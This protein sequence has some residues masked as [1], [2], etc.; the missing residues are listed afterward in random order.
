MLSHMVYV[1]CLSPWVF[2]DFQVFETAMFVSQLSLPCKI[3][4]LI[5]RFVCHIQQE[6]EDVPYPILKWQP[7]SGDSMNWFKGKSAGNPCF[8]PQKYSFPVDFPSNQFWDGHVGSQKSVGTIQS[9]C[10]AHHRPLC[11]FCR[12]CGSTDRAHTSDISGHI[13]RHQGVAYFMMTQ[14]S[15]MQLLSCLRFCFGSLIS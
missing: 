14:V 4:A 11:F 5:M 8:H 12:P 15:C 9:T 13:R 3:H 1:L 2:T 7:V 10:G 6:A